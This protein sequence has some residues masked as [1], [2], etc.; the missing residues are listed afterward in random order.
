MFGN[1]KYHQLG[2]AVVFLGLSWGRGWMPECIR[3]FA[4]CN[5]RREPKEMW[6][7]KFGVAN[8]FSYLCAVFSFMSADNAAKPP[9]QGRLLTRQ[10]VLFY[11]NN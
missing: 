1:K 10:F 3:K 5:I 6:T 9:N 8:T 2:Q 11:I 4:K 7:E